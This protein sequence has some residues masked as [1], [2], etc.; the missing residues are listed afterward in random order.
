[1]PS[2]LRTQVKKRLRSAKYPGGAPEHAHV[3]S[4]MSAFGQKLPCTSELSR[5]AACQSV[6]DLF[7]RFRLSRFKGGFY[8]AGSVEQIG[9][10][11]DL[12][13]IKDGLQ[14]GNRLE[15]LAVF[16]R[17]GRPRHSR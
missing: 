11:L 8:Q 4:L 12:H 5:C 14:A 17:A 15:V 16:C 1:M 9:S 3:V 6:D 7:Q 10:S 2:D 13:K